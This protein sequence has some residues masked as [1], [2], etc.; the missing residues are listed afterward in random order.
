MLAGRPTS[1]EALIAYAVERA[2]IQDVQ[3]MIGA[4]RAAAAAEPSW[5]MTAI[6]M[7]EIDLQTRGGGAARRWLARSDAL[8]PASPA[9][10]IVR[11]GLLLAEARSAR[12]AGDR[13]QTAAGL[14]AAL[15][16][17]PDDSD[18]LLD[19]AA[20]AEPAPVAAASLRRSL[21]CRTWAGPF[22][23]LG[24]LE[25]AA[26]RLTAAVGRYRQA[27]A[28]D[29]AHA[30]GWNNL[31]TVYRDSAALPAALLGYRRA[32][33]ADPSMATTESNLLQ[34]LQFDPTIGD[35]Q[36]AVAHRRWSE[37]HAL[38]VA[39]PRQAFA[40]RRDPN[41]PLTIGYVSA[42]LG[43]HPVGFFLLPV[44]EAHDRSRVRTICY[45][46]RDL[47][48]EVSRALRTACDTWADATDHSDDSLAARIRADSIDILVDLSGHTAHHRLMVFARRPAPVQATWLGY[49]DTTGLD[50]IDYLLT[51]RWEVPDDRRARFAEEVVTLTAGRFAYRPPAYA[52]T[53]AS[54]PSLEAKRIT[55]GSFNNLGKVTEPVIR[56][57]SRILAAIDDARLLLKWPSLEDRGVAS[58]IERRF[59]PYGIARN[60]L[61]LRGGS[62]HD[63]MLAEYGDV[64]VALD[65][66]PFSGCL[67]TVEAL[68]MG[69]PV[70]TLE[71]GR[72]VARQS[73][74]ILS[75][76]GLRELAAEDEESYV[77]RAVA[78]AMD[79]DLRTTL[80]GDLRRRM[81]ASTLLDG[82]AVAASLEDAYRMMWRRWCRNEEGSGRR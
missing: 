48:D 64:D 70:V 18:A 3:S 30:I 22:V 2:S 14:R 59:A 75:R 60:R 15:A 73:A 25:K 8:D 9:A 76:L 33:S 71:G 17:G 4:L 36:L 24:N 29:P 51:D 19:L 81:S 45:A 57:W 72:P 69:V 62:P 7:A 12:A 68:W 32:L 38:Q 63:A 42:D 52:P 21:A 53:P 49:F 31:A 77:R 26:N 10:P 27:I 47:D 37:H 65:P 66:F 61:D 28:T 78:L 1:A 5:S 40:N 44:I 11:R 56:V 50:A 54:P 16:L 74:A 13:S 58:S 67:T 20:L 43:R 46:T 35:L 23:N 41:R 79:V 39:S 34:A 80:R 82:R 6:R 55:F